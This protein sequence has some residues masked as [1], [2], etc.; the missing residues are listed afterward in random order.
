M[1]DEQLVD[2]LPKLDVARANTLGMCIALEAAEFR[3][4][5][6]DLLNMRVALRA[7]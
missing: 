1:R 7:H 6:K 2:P 5:F 4:S 3:Q